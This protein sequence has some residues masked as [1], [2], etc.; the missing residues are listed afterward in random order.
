MIRITAIKSALAVL[1]VLVF[2]GVCSH[3]QSADASTLSVGRFVV[4]A[5]EG[6][7]SPL[8]S[9]AILTQSLVWDPK[10]E[11]FAYDAPRFRPRKIAQGIDP[12]LSP[13][14]SMVAYCGFVPGQVVSQIMVMKSD[15][16]GQKQ[17]TNMGG[18]PCAPA[19]SPDGMKIAFSV[20][21]GRGQAVMVLDFESKTIT[22]IALGTLPR[23]SPDGKHL[24]FLRKPETHGAKA[25]IWA[26]DADGKHARLVV[27]TNALIPSA[28]WGSDGKSILYTNDDHLR[29][30]IFRV[31][32]DG[33]NSE[34]FAGD[35]NLEMYFPT[36]SPD[37]KKIAVVI[38]DGNRLMLMEIDLATQKSRWLANGE[39]GDVVW[40]KSH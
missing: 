13:D 19:W 15:G 27:D 34:K 29:S 21:S 39:R 33:T 3:A 14:G 37:G 12:A 23:W 4:Q 38:A 24:L 31:N 9:E 7:N 17:L 28:V 11:I 30:A 5:Y 36:M 8:L 10:G 1:L 32:M 35:K 25:S 16:S 6:G 2:A 20:E 26:A 40:V 22:P 18:S